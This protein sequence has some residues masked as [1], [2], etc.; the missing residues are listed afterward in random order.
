MRRAAKVDFNHSEIVAT[1]RAAGISVYDTSAVGGG[2]SDLVCGFGKR[3][4]NVEIKDGA[5][6][7]S[8]RKLTGPQE[9]FVANWK[10]HYVVI[11]SIE[12]ARL[13]CAA[14]TKEP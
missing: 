3:S 5:K 6:S 1:I 10:G 12:Q 7:P 2:F 13:W 11:E 14:V 4:F 8:R 9:D